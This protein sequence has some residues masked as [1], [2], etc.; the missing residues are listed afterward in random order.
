LLWMNM[1]CGMASAKAATL[2]QQQAD[3]F[4]EIANSYLAGGNNKKFCQRQ[5]LSIP[6]LHAQR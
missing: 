3:A 2:F 5:V 1:K 4:A 6:R